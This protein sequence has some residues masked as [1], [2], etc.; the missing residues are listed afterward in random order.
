M[1]KGNF[2]EELKRDE[3]VRSPSEGIR[4]QRF[5]N[6]WALANILST[7]GGRSLRSPPA[8]LVT[9]VNQMRCVG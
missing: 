5:R 1:G 9:T 8:I 3:C 2:S 7:R 6:G 4:S